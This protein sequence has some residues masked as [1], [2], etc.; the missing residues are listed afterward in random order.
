VPH[1]RLQLW[2]DPQRVF[3]ELFGGSPFAFWLDGVAGS[4][5]TGT[6][7]LTRMGEA[8][9]GRSV[10]LGRLGRPTVVLDPA[11]GIHS[12]DGRDPL[13]IAEA[14]STGGAGSWW[15]WLGYEWGAGRA[16]AP[17][18][19]EGESTGSAP[20]V[21]LLYSARVVTF[22]HDAR[23]IEL[24]FEAGGAGFAW[25]ARTRSSLDV[26]A[27]GETDE[28]APAGSQTGAALTRPD[29]SAATAPVWRHDDD[30][31]LRLIDRCLAHIRAGDAYQLCLTNEAVV[32]GRFDPLA[33]YL[34]L[35]T[36]DTAA[37]GGF[38][39]FGEWALL[40]ASPEEFL[41]VGRGGAIRTRPIKGTRPRGRTA[42][43]DELLR[44]DLPNDPKERAE[45][46]MIV[47]LMRNDLERIAER[48]S[49]RWR[50]CGTFISSSARSKRGS[51][52]A[53]R[54]HPCWMPPSPPDR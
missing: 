7:R 50:R 53:H 39:R 21:A 16:G 3:H 17:V 48:A 11:T 24:S 1:H 34:R 36:D 43:E 46:L 22:H 25:A 42:A 32:P 45:N 38:L 49:S 51:R 28:R 9:G 5:H 20:D 10:L 4:D 37:H 40:S 18:T 35:R 30:A 13:V 44:S 2:V 14:R 31:Y 47:D 52:R 6:G 23:Q 8:A 41:R 12:L 27:T 26:L 15:G 54:S 19:V 29:P 33:V